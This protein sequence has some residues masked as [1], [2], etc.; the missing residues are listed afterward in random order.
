MGAPE[1]EH[2]CEWRDQYGELKGKH[3]A[4]AT[5]FSTLKHEFEMM[6]RHLLGPKSE[7]MPRVK[8]E[9]RKDEANDE[10]ALAKR[11]ADAAATRKERANARKAALATKTTV[12]PVPADERQCPKCGL[13]KLKTVGT[14]KESVVYE[15]KPAHFIAHRHVR[16]TLACPCNEYVVTAEGP[17]KWVEKSQYAPSFVAHI[18]TAKCADAL[19]L[20]RLEKEL[21]RI[22][23]PVSRSTMTDL[24]HRAAD[25]LAPLYE[26]LLELV[27]TADVVRADETSKKVMAE[28]KCHTGFIWTFRA[29]VPQPLITYKFAMSRSGET[30]RE[31]LGGTRGKLVVDGYTGYNEVTAVNGRIRVGCN[32]HSRRYF[33][34]AQNAAPVESRSAID[35]ILGLYRVERD[36]AAAGVLGTAE[37][38][39][40]RQERSGPIREAFKKWLDEQQPNFG[41]KTPMGRAIKYTLN[42]WVHL[43]RFLEDPAIP[44]DNNE[45]EAA[46]R[47]VALGRKNF[48]WV[49]NETAGENL[50]GLYSLV[51]TC[52][53]NDINPAAYL[54]D[55]LWRVN[56][57]PN[58]KLD[59]LLPHLWHEPPDAAPSPSA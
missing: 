43:G 2:Q 32:A 53:A 15:Y 14:G 5:D 8:D 17:T 59:E 39:K 31:V 57:H 34:E 44:L 45:S 25:Q 4:L 7:K 27:R 54:A 24:F 13:E 11:R 19:P 9:L 47:R 18:I 49:G 1:A 21:H 33:F 10:A 40:M 16:E 55:V 37:H 29:R 36:A 48:L 26:R 52:E 28:G 22:G 6:K 12:H 20:Y 3:E 42:Q 58:A 56:D 30:P 46:L 38:L 51:A 41:P 35:F 50:A 23:V